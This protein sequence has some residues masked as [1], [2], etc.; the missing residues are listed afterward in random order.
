MKE[1]K[2]E[3]INEVSLLCFIKEDTAQNLSGYI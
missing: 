1:I 3:E 2:I